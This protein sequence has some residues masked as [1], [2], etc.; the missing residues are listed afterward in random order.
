MHDCYTR[1]RCLLEGVWRAFECT[2]H[3]MGRAPTSIAVLFA[4]S[5]DPSIFT[6]FHSMNGDISSRQIERNT[7]LVI[8]TLGIVRRRFTRHSSI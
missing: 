4:L 1:K 6:D 2:R 8:L 5:T 7:V 3:K